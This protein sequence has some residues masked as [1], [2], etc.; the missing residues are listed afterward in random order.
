MIDLTADAAVEAVETV[1]EV[2]IETTADGEEE[3]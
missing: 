2:V 1:A 3:C